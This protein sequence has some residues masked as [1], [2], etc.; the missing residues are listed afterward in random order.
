MREVT[1]K[2][3]SDK[4]LQALNELAKVFD[5]SIEQSAKNTTEKKL[6]ITFAE[7]PDVKALA[8]IWEGRNIT[9][10]ELRKKAWGDRI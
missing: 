6:P 9:L 1:I 2:Y 3:K 7:D 5:I 4:F 10:D 8:G